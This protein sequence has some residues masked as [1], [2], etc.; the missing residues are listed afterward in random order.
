MSRL[1]QCA[2]QMNQSIETYRYH[3]AAQTIWHFIWDDFCDWYIELKKGSG[4]WAQDQ[5]LSSNKPCRLLHPLMP[6]IT[7]ELWH[8]LRRTRGRVD[9]TAA[10]SR[11]RSHS[12]TT[13]RPKRKSNFCRT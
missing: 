2:R 6:F 13:L 9:L 12:E 10:L 11:I 8:R 1:N 4:D 7:E 3:E 5:R